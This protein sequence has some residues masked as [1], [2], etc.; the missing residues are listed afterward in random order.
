MHGETDP[1]K[2]CQLLMM[3][4]RGYQ[5]GNKSAHEVFGGES[6]ALYTLGAVSNALDAGHYGNSME[7][8]VHDCRLV[9]GVSYRK[10]P[11]WMW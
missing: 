5:R 10:Y 6:T 9:W 2:R 7:K 4:L 8:F 11:A 1:T 3:A